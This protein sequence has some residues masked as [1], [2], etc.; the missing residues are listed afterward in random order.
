MSACP[1]LVNPKL[2]NLMHVPPSICCIVLVTEVWN[3]CMLTANSS[4]SIALFL[5]S[6]TEAAAPMEERAVPSSA[7][8]DIDG[9]VGRE[10]SLVLPG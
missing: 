7:S 5:D 10:S 2:K 4:L 6:G 9:V 8:D 1:K 3:F